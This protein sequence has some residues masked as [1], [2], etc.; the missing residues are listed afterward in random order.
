MLI[1]SNSISLCILLCLITDSH[2]AIALFSFLQLW[3]IHFMSHRQFDSFSCVFF[4]SVMT[5]SPSSRAL[6]I[7]C[8]TLSGLATFTDVKFSSH[9]EIL[10]IEN[11]FL[12]KQFK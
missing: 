10:K 2:I 8:I 7:C 4:A 12:N 11:I 6:D 3:S 5:F 9:N 1:S